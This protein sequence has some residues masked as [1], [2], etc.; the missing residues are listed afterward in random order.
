MHKRTYFTAALIGLIMLLAGCEQRQSQN[1]KLHVVASVDF[2]GEVAQ[3]V[4]GKYGTVTSV[5][6]DPN[7]DPHDY[8]P[9]SQVGKTVAQA[10][11]LI[12]NGAGYDSWMTKLA[13]AQPDTPMITAA[14]VV[15]VK[16]GENEH[17]W[18]KPQAM[19]LMATALAKRFGKLDPKHRHTYA[20]NAKRYM[21]SLKPLD[22]VVSRLT[23]SAQGQAAIVSEPVFNNALQAIGMKV[24][25][26]HFAQAIE[27]G[28]DPTPA[29]IQKNTH[30]LTQ[31][32]VA[33]VVINQQVQSK[34][35]TN[36]TQVAKA[37]Q[38]PILQVTETMPRGKT[39]VQWQVS[40]YRNLIKLLEK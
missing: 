23:T 2:Y 8:Q 27:E 22:E 18:Y 40:Q 37:N 3:Q 30:L 36:L 29:D 21:T 10:D 31:H 39:Y 26:A 33:F 12:A 35:I 28:S 19:K 17:I 5:I 20:R 11:V 16:N 32:Q 7:V 1:G 34:L 6:K 9:T 13:K 24:A 14:K 15:G 38:V 4:L 25:D